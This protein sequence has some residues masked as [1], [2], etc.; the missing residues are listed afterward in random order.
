MDLAWDIQLLKSFLLSAALLNIGIMLLWIALLTWSRNF[1]HR[2]HGF[3]FPMS[4]EK[5]IELHYL[6]F[7]LYK[8]G[9]FLFFLMP[10]IALTLLT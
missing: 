3:W 1:I 6:M 10:W 7:G 9:I 2:F 5:M 4:Q 8:L